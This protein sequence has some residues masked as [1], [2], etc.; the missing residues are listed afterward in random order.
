MQREAT[1]TFI[2]PLN[3]VAVGAAFV[4]LGAIVLGVL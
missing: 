1:M 3:I 2:R 4:F